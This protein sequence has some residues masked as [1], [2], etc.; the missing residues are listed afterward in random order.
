M[1][2]HVLVVLSNAVE[3]QDEQFNR[4]YTEQ[5]LG[6]VLRVPGFTA[7]QRFVL[8]ETQLRSDE[9]PYRYLA[10]YEVE[11][12]ELTATVQALAEA[13]GTMMISPALDRDRTVAWFF[14]PLTERVTALR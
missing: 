3:G 7:A 5:H 4:W 1:G 6:D 11:T 2:K 8:S 12:D 9:F 13:A 10:I 14:T